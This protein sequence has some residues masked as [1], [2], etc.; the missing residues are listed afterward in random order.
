MAELSLVRNV[1]DTVLMMLDLRVQGGLVSHGTGIGAKRVTIRVWYQTYSRTKLHTVIHVGIRT[2]VGDGIRRR[3]ERKV[4]RVA[5]R[6]G[7]VVWEWRRTSLFALAPCRQR[8]DVQSEISKRARERDSWRTLVLRILRKSEKFRTKAKWT[9]ATWASQPPA[10]PKLG[11]RTAFSTSNDKPE[12]TP[13]INDE[14]NYEG[15][16]CGLRPGSHSSRTGHCRALTRK[17]KQ[18][19]NSKRLLSYNF[20][21]L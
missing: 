4:E 18:P 1:R 5:K 2:E 15:R 12:G 17:I 16:S 8:R 7:V 21:A 20:A 11:Q 14:Y 19:A 10:T 3:V 9:T 13:G 6:D